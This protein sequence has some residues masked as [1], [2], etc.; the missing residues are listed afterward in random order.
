[1]SRLVVVG[2]RCSGSILVGSGL[3]ENG[4]RGRFLSGMGQGWTAK[5]VLSK[6]GRGWL[7]SLL[8]TSALV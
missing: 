3:P 2:H 1:M 6:K 4:Q 7:R 8:V 5:V